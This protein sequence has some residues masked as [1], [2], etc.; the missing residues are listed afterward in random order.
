MATVVAPMAERPAS[1]ALLT[2]RI[3]TPLKSS[4]AFRNFP[5]AVKTERLVWNI[6]TTLR[7]PFFSS[8]S[9]RKAAASEVGHFF[10]ASIDDMV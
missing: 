6:Q 10:Q 1:K 2:P 7:T 8:S 4:G 3:L 9:S 5:L